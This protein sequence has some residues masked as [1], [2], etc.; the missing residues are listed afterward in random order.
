MTWT[1]LDITCMITSAGNLAFIPDEQNI[2]TVTSRRSARQAL[3]VMSQ[4]VHSIIIAF[5]AHA[6]DLP[7]A[8]IHMSSL[9]WC[10]LV[11]IVMNTD[12]AKIQN[13]LP[14]RNK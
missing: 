8:T 2:T 7:L 13:L 4:A 12:L 5:T 14:S 1:T 11:R 9:H 6:L 3:C 10:V